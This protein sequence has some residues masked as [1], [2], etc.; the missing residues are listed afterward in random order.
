MTGRGLAFADP[1]IVR[2]LQTDFVPVTGDDWYRRRQQDAVGTFFRG[3]ADQGPRKGEDGSTRQ[4]LYCFTGDGRLLAYR[5]SSD[6][7]AVSTLLNQA[8]EAWRNLPEAARRPKPFAADRGKPDPQFDRAPPEGGVVV[9]VHARELEADGKGRWREAAPRDSR[10][11]LASLDHLWLTKEEWQSLLPPRA[12]E[13]LPYPVPPAI[14]RRIARFHLVDNTR[15]EPPMWDAEDVRQ[16]DMTLK[17]EGV[18]KGTAAL[19]LDGR[20]RLQTPDGGRGYDA[21]I[22]GRLSCDHGGRVSRF[23]AVAIGMH[24]GEGRYTPGARPGK[25]PLGLAF[26]LA[27]GAQEADKV[28]PQAARDL[29]TYYGRD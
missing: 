20:V 25:T 8:L 27:D 11:N 28:P 17:M 13:G 19:R 6:P 7:A 26:V 10:P 15:G 2:T 23:D 5:N 21:E 9:R 18:D 4:G 22:F 24:W 29:G 1:K 12:G 3:V 14:A 16:A